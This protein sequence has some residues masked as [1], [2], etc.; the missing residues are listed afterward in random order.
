MDFIVEDLKGWYKRSGI[1]HYDCDSVFQFITFRL[2]DSL[3]QHVIERWKTELSIMK[4][5]DKNSEEY[6]ELQRKIIKYEDEG[7]GNCY[8]KIPEIYKIVEATFLKFNNVKYELISWVIMPNHVHLLIRQL[9]GY[10]IGE[11]VQSWKVYTAKMA[12]K[13]LNR[14]GKFWMDDYYDR[15]I[16]NEGHYY[17][18]IDYINNNNKKKE[19]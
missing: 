13:R 17:R 18:V 2:F 3:P 12:N 1:P 19:R 4:N 7:F 15:F 11:I 6:Q 8:L 5:H 14:K 9:K 16:R 10:S